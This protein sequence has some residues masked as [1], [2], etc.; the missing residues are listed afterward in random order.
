MF[1]YTLYPYTVK[2]EILKEKLELSQT[3]CSHE[4][5]N[6]QCYDVLLFG[7]SVILRQMTFLSSLNKKEYLILKYL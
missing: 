5:W 1:D 3:E 4:K 6:L 7:T 2:I